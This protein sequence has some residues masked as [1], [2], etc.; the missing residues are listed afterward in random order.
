MS[1]KDFNPDGDIVDN[2]LSTISEPLWS[3]SIGTL[4]TF[5]TGSIQ[6]SNT[7]K[8]LLVQIDP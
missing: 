6:S 8:Y 2:Q 4:T 3:D 1:F 5:F 7:G